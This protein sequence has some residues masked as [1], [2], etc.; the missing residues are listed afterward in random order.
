MNRKEFMSQLKRALIPLRQSARQE[1][2]T[3]LEEH[4]KD[5]AAL[6][7][8]DF[9]VAEELGN[10][11]ELAQQYLTSAKANEKA[12]IPENVGRGIFVGFGLLLLDAMI[13]I[14][15][16]AGIFATI[17]GLWAVPIST[18]ASSIAL[19]IH[20]FFSVVSIGIPYYLTFLVSIALLGFTA[21]SAIGLFY[22]SKYYVKLI[23][24]LAKMHYKMIVGGSRG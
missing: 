13:V 10:P 15:I 20:P 3:D 1:I 2:L 12:S 21:A 24:R 18:F 6:G 16:A 11:K 19:I 5:G 4:F 22:L 17:I 9:E 14:P 23:V 7:K 8:T